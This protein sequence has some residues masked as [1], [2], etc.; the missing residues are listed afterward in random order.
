MIMKNKGWMSVLFLFILACIAVGVRIYYINHLMDEVSINEDIY[1]A[2]KI[3]LGNNGLTSAFADGFHMQSLYIYTLYLFFLLFGNFTVAGVYLNILYQ[4]FTVLLVYIIAKN[5]SNRYIGFTTG[6]IVSVI[7]VYIGNLSQVTML[8]M[9]IFIA[10]VLCAVISCAVRIFYNRRKAGKKMEQGQGAIPENIAA[11]AEPAACPVLD[12]S[13]KEIVLD[14]LEDKKVQY[15]ENPL[16]VPKRR[17]HKEM[18]FAF[19][20][21]GNDDY[22]L[23]DM[24]GKDF[25]DIE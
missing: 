20:P 24:S 14:D 17:E 13:M 11:A 21:T 18:D 15:I 2:A 6:V 23:K 19:E 1:N 22:D 8:N 25:F 10:A 5:V 12:T 16:P 4:V 9:E 7:P 3:S